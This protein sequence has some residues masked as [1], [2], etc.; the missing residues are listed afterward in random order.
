MILPLFNNQFKVIPE[1][2]PPFTLTGIFVIIVG[3]KVV[4]QGFRKNLPVNPKF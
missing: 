2:T 3:E 1:A 4:S